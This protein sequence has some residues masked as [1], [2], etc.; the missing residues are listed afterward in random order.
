MLSFG[1]E[2]IFSKY[3]EIINNHPQI[4]QSKFNLHFKTNS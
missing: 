1:N 4:Q 2:R 3:K